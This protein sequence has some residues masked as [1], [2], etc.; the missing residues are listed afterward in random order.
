M[1]EIS[2]LGEYFSPNKLVVTNSEGNNGEYN[3]LDRGGS[4]FLY[5]NTNLN[6]VIKMIPNVHSAEKELHIHKLMDNLAPTLHFHSPP[7]G[8]QVRVIDDPT[9]YF[10]GG[11]RVFILIMEYLNPEDW[12]PITNIDQLSLYNSELFDF[13]HELIFIKGYRNLLDFLGITGNHLFISKEEEIKI[14][15]LGAFQPVVDAQQDYLSMIKGL[16]DDLAIIKPNPACQ[17]Q[18]MDLGRSLDDIGEDCKGYFLYWG[19][20]FL[21]DRLS[22]ERLKKKPRS[23]KKKKKKKKKKK[24]KKKKSKRSLKGNKRKTKKKKSKRK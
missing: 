21:E 19:R 12:T 11:A 10:F 1:I 23:G 16:E 6:K 14:L 15:D 9:T 13:I 4:G 24:S 3:F 18:I 20:E 7:D 17:K 22:I 8:L 5:V 2:G